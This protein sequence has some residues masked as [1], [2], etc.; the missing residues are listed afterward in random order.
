MYTEESHSADSEKQRKSQTQPSI[1]SQTPGT[2]SRANLS[3]V[4]V[5]TPPIFSGVLPKNMMNHAEIK[6]LVDGAAW[7]LNG[8][9]LGAAVYPDILLSEEVIK[10]VK[11]MKKSKL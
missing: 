4:C 7:R 9:G 8:G 2:S 6:Y 5:L 11:G 10:D 1:S 3:S